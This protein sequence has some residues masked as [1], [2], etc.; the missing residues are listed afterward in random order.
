MPFSVFYKTEPEFD[1]IL[2]G[3]FVFCIIIIP[4]LTGILFSFVAGALSFVTI[5]EVLII[6]ES[7][8]FRGD[9]HV[10]V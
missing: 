5:M 3:V 4:L 7:M 6:E 8:R 2:Q 9:K 1:R 10:A